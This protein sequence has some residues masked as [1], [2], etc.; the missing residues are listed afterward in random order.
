[1][2]GEFSGLLTGQPRLVCKTAALAPLARSGLGLEFALIAN[3]RPFTIDT[4]QLSLDCL[5]PVPE[6]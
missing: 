2:A 1:M 6:Y 3:P 4:T 5:A